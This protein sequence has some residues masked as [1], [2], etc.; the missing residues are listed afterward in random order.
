MESETGELLKHI[1]ESH[2]VTKW[3]AAQWFKVA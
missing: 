1:L 3:K 2:T